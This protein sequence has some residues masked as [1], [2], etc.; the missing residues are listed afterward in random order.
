MFGKDLGAIRGRTVR[1]TPKALRID[2]SSVFKH[3]DKKVI[4]AADLAFIEQIPFLVTISRGLGLMTVQNV[5]SKEHASIMAAVRHVQL[6]YKKHGFVVH[7]LLS[8][9]ESAV[10][11]MELALGD[12]GIK[13]NLA[14]KGE[15]VPE[16]ERAIRVKADLKRDFRLQFGSYV[17]VHEDD[18]ITNTMKPRTT[19]AIS[20]GPSG[21]MQGA[22]K[23]LSLDTWKVIVRRSWTELPI[24]NDVLRLINSKTEDVDVGVDVEV[25]VGGNAAGDLVNEDD[26]S[27]ATAKQKTKY[28]AETVVPH[29]PESS[30]D[31]RSF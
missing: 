13:L 22:Y 7:M 23:F 28:A 1:E 8:D 18:S 11:G 26:H 17:Q 20:L 19:G 3:E 16:V 2:T 9:T 24:P 31:K 25:D 15:H 27:T 10:K 5:E 4:L 21:N 29:N 6:L 12:I 14:S 30:E